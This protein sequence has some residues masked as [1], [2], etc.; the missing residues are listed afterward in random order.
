MNSSWLDDENL[1]EKAVEASRAAHND[2]G[3]HTRY[4]RSRENIHIPS[5]LKASAQRVHYF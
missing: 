4:K 3:I 5:N 1:T 2:A